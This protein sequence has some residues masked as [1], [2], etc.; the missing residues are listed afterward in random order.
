MGTK[1]ITSGGAQF[2]IE[3]WHGLHACDFGAL[4]PAP[5]LRW[6]SVPARLHCLLATVRP[7]GPRPNPLLLAPWP[8]VTPATCAS[9]D[10]APTAATTR[11]APAPTASVPSRMRA[12]GCTPIVKWNDGVLAP[13]R[14]PVGVGRVIAGS[15]GSGLRWGAGGGRLPV[16]VWG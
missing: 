11:R 5:P 16:G 3:V 14:Q 12:S 13:K 8:T 4:L 10:R 15:G 1:S 9:G 6:P 2:K 7:H